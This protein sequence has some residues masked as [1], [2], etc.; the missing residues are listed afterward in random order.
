MIR[1]WSR[2]RQ[3]WEAHFLH[4]EFCVSVVIGIGFGVWIFQFDGEHVLQG[5]LDARRSNLYG[6]LVGVFVSLLGSMFTVTSITIVMI[7]FNRMKLIR[8]SQA[9]PALVDTYIS[10]IIWLSI[11]L[12]AALT[13]QWFE[14]GSR[15]GS[16]LVVFLVFSSAVSGCRVSRVVWIVAK[17]FRI[18]TMSRS[19]D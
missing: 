11:S 9:L 14:D 10:A 17:L 6:S 16:V 12:A 18:M 1:T 19:K 13:C 15:F 4:W 3:I 8:K 5:F 7:N 2:F